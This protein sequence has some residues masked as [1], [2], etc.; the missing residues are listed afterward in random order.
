MFAKHVFNTFRAKWLTL[1]LLGVIILLSGFIYTTMS[2]SLRALQMGADDYFTT[3]MQEDASI[4]LAPNIDISAIPCVPDGVRTLPELYLVDKACHT[5]I[6][7]AQLTLLESAFDQATFEIRLYKN[8][9]VDVH[10]TQHAWRIL[11]NSTT[12]NLTHV[13]AG[14]IPE[15]ADEVAIGKLYAENNGLAL[16]DQI[17]LAGMPRTIV[18][19]VLFPDYNLPIIE[20]PFL[21]DSV[22]QT[23]ALLH[24]D[25]FDILPFAAEYNIAVAFASPAAEKAFLEAFAELDIASFATVILTE[26][27][28]RSGAIYG[29]LAGGQAMGLFM[30]VMIALIGLLIVGLVM[31]K[32]LNKERQ[33]LGVLKA[34]GYEKKEVARPYLLGLAVFSLGFL[35]IGFLIGQWT[36]PRLRDFYLT[37]YLLPQAAVTLDPLDIF[38]AI[39]VP[40]TVIMGLSAVI[41]ERLLKEEA[42][43]LLQPK[44]QTVKPLKFKRLAKWL[45]R[46]S[47]R[48]RFQFKHLLRQPAKVGAYVLGI[49]LALYAVFLG[50]SMLDVFSKTLTDYYDTLDVT[51]IGYC[52][53]LQPCFAEGQDR[54]LELPVMTQGERAMLIGLDPDNRLHP[55]RDRR[56]R[57][58]LGDLDAG[59]VITRSFQ[60]LTRVKVGDTLTLDIMGQTVTGDVVAV[61]DLYPG[62]TL[63]TSRSILNGALGLD[64]ATFNVVHSDVPLDD[65][66]F[67]QVITV[68]SIMTQAGLMNRIMQSM[69]TVII[70][71]AFGIGLTVV[72]LLSVLSVEDQFYAISLLKVIGYENR[73]VQT[74]MLGAYAKLNAV[75]FVFS[76]PLTLLSLVVLQRVFIDMYSFVIPL[77]LELWHIG[78]TALMFAV[79]FVLG[80]QHAKR[81][82][83]TV[84]LQEALKIY[85]V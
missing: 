68:A 18:G 56:G 29:E 20:H 28:I 17:I 27:N 59:F 46:F 77:S 84:A 62:A 4:E 19:F 83:N 3:Y 72:F 55:L 50:F 21:Y 47:V 31:G 58:L 52:E 82:I 61:A 73:E 22:Y 40:F 34:L 74:M 13:E 30:S 16:G 80:S 71:S 41:L 76:L 33:S 5:W 11:K 14:R 49:F 8:T 64:A 23:L 45:D 51:H 67:A 53:P 75:V 79:I 57:S 1:V 44:L 37:F 25:A 2:A 69:M 24:D 7:D 35:G 78:V 9:R 85:Q 48:L 15:D 26:N 38:I 42:V 12:L 81:K 54:V 43:G 6:L 10:G 60:D 66:D 39:L 36:A 32:T 65:A 63:F 70:V